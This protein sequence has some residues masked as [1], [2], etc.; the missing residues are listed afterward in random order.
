MQG[1]EKWPLFAIYCRIHKATYL[2]A[3]TFV[4]K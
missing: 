3:T 1:I 4:P 2:L